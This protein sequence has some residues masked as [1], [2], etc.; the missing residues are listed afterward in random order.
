MTTDDL[1]RQIQE[2]ERLIVVYRNANEVIVG[3]PDE[4]YAS[5]GLINRT[6]LTAAENI[7]NWAIILKNRT[8]PRREGGRLGGGIS[9]KR[10]MISAAFAME[11]PGL[12]QMPKIATAAAAR[13][14]VGALQ[15]R[16]N[17][18]DQPASPGLRCPRC[19]SRN[20]KLES[21]SLQRRVDCEPDFLEPVRILLPPPA[22]LSAMHPE[23]CRPEARASAAVRAGY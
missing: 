18:V 15:P 6:T 11:P 19:A 10:N 23:S 9:A 2:M 20:R 12:V 3:T 7:G 13:I 21:I 5:R 8:W 4:V 1:M 16:Q 17:R 22:S 14:V